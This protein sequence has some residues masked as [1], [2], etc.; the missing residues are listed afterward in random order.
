MKRIEARVK[1]A[2]PQGLRLD[3]FV[4]ER[5]GLFSR[6]QAKARI[7]EARVNGRSV[8]LSHKL[9]PGDLVSVEYTDAP[10]IDLLPEEIP[11]NIL[12]EN[13]DVIV[14]DK[15]Q[16]MVV[17]PGSG[18]PGGTLLN[19]L[20]FHCKGLGKAFGKEEPRPGIV[21]RL[22]KETSGVL[23]AAKNPRAHELLSAQF[24]SRRAR[25]RYLALV[26]GRPRELRGNVETRIARDPTNRKRFAISK[27]LGRIAT[28][29]YLVL[30]LYSIPAD[31]RSK[32]G[33]PARIYGFVS[34]YPRTGRTHQLRVHMKHLSAPILGD[35]LYGRIDPLFAGISL[36]LHAHKLSIIL[37]GETSPREFTAPLPERFRRALRELH[38]R[39]RK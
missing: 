17:H 36:M 18:N 7:T 20:L 19:A 5:L 26:Q 32:T 39:A 16:G 22:D 25:K 27:D 15:P 6:S 29:G 37:P 12:F 28:T 10:P 21:H 24:K 31:A 13:E 9:K 38:S 4:S 23:I 34:L 35:A 14:I 11:L 8:R 3:L 2:E 30:R 33:A 1:A